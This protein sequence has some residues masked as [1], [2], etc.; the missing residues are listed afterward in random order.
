MDN[1]KIW[2]P[3]A[4]LFLHTITFNYPDNPNEQ[5]KVNF[6]TFFDSLKH[7]LPCEKCKK[8]YRENSKDLKENL[9]S[10]DDLVKWLIDIHNQVN[11]QNNKSVWSYTDV[12]NKYQDIYNSSNTINNVLIIVIILIVLF[13][14]FFLFNIY[15]GNK[16]G[17]K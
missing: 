1:N 16:T 13:F 6:F 10:K 7:V 5:D 15:H 17:C 3:D 12:Y 14:V 8:H 4:W 11:I 9:N 2:G